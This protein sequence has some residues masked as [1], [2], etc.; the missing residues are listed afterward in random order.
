M[1]QRFDHVGHGDAPVLDQ[2]QV[3][4]VF[5][6]GGRREVVRAH[7][8]AG[9]RFVEVDHDKLVVH[10]HSHAVGAQRAG[11]ALEGLRKI[12]T[13]VGREYGRNLAI[14]KMDVQATSPLV[15]DAI[16]E[17]ALFSW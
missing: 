14:G 17:D 9:G 12:L 11:F 6:V 10:A 16:D 5:V 4:A 1:G 13:K 7:I 3:L 8:D 15:G 2:E